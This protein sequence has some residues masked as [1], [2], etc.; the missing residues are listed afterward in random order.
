MVGPVGIQHPN[1]RH[2]WIPVFLIPVIVLDVQEV[3]KCHGKTQ[4][5]VQ[6]AERIFRHVCKAVKHGNVR[7][8]LVLHHQR[9]RLRLVRLSGIHRI[10]AV[11]LDPGKLFLCDRPG[12]HIGSGGADDRLLFFI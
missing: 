7:R 9:L 12:Q 3:L 2:G 10:D 4:G 1:L 6:R 5:I 11:L 8:L